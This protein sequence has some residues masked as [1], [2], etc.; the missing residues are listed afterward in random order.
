MGKYKHRS[1]GEKHGHMM[2]KKHGYMMPKKAGKMKQEMLDGEDTL[3]TM[4]MGDTR[5]MKRGHRHVIMNHM[6]PIGKYDY[7][8]TD[9]RIARDFA[10]NAAYDN[11][12]GDKSAANYEAKQA[13]KAMT[14]K[15]GGLFG[16]KFRPK[17]GL[18]KGTK[19]RKYASKRKQG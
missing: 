14:R 8:K 15:D 12:H 11:E 6:S 5:L 3:Q 9:A 7:K 17:D 1:L 2:P 16:G 13:E 4:K 18:V 19:K 10:A